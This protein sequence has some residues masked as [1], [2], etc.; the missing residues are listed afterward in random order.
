MPGPCLSAANG[1]NVEMVMGSSDGGWRFGKTIN[2]AKRSI[3]GLV[4]NAQANLA[5]FL[6]TLTDEQVVLLCGLLASTGFSGAESAKIRFLMGEA[7][8]SVCPGADRFVR[9]AGAKLF[10]ASFI[11]AVEKRPEVYDCQGAWALTYA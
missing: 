10:G 8:V 6:L 3:P 11:I 2:G 1:L 7:V 4:P 5:R 9:A